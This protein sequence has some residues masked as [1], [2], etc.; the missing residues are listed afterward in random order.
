MPE[1][2]SLRQDVERELGWEPIVRSAEIG[3]AVKEGVVMLS[4]A[5]ESYPAKRAA[6][7]AAARV[8]GVKAVSSQ[9]EVRPGG[10]EERSDPGIA[11]AAANVLAWNALVPA[12]RIRVEVSQGWITLEGSVDWRFQR[13]AAEDAVAD[14]AGVVGVTN[15]IGVCPSV[16][17]EE[18]R[19]EIE[20]ALQRSAE[21]DARR[22]IVETSGDCVTLWGS[23][24]SQA[25]RDAAE[26]AA[27]SAPGVR[28][29]SNHISVESGVA[30]V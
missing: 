6:E 12:D 22:I 28:D 2:L 7:R 13:T 21:L 17:P 15:L 25:Q 11:W 18:I 16:P 27:W 19:G 20:T 10:P 14:L 26:Q 3:V 1:D 23:V 4:G 5:V 30:A 8:R 29:V 9:L 24:D